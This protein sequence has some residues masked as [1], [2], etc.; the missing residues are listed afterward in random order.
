MPRRAHVEEPLKNAIRPVEL[1]NAD[2]DRTQA[3]DLLLGRHRAT[4]PRICVSDCAVIDENEA[5]TLWIFEMQGPPAVTL[6]D[7]MVT[8]LAFVQSFQPPLQRGLA[9]NAQPGANDAVSSPFLASSGPVKESKVCSGTALPVGVEEMIGGNVVLIDCLFHEAHPEN[10]CVKSVI[11]PG[12]CRDRCEMMDSVELHL[13]AY[14]RI[15]LFT[16]LRKIRERRSSRLVPSVKPSAPLNRRL[17]KRF[18]T[19][20]A[21]P[22]DQRSSNE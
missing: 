2:R 18:R 10:V 19:S 7:S 5:L 15:V 4:F 3:A 6:D 13:T 21:W 22:R 1:R 20:A 11:A 14:T 8:Y 12:V 9:A 17:A 16:T